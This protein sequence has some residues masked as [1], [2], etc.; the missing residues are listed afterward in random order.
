[1]EGRPPL[2]GQAEADRRLRAA[3]VRVTAQ[4]RAVYEALAADPLHPTVEAV[5]SRVKKNWP[6]LPLPTVY[7]IVEDLTAAGL[8]RRVASDGGPQRLDANAER[9]QHLVCRACGRMEDWTHAG[10]SGLS[11]PRGLPDG[12]SGEAYDIRIV[13]LCRS[14]SGKAGARGRIPKRRKS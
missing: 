7:R 11:L 1:M 2:L 9:H 5:Y 4:R 8:I 10:L 12:F 14:C 13:G 6:S 3:G